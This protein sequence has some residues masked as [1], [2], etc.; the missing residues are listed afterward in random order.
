M[1]RF[2]KLTAAAAAAMLLAACGTG[3]TGGGGGGDGDNTDKPYRI[4]VSGGVSAP[5]VMADLSGTSINATKAAVEDVNDNG[6]IAGRKIELVVVDDAGDPTTA[7]T[8]LR[9]EIN[10]KGVDAYLNSGPSTIA[11]ATLPILTQNKILSFNIGPTAESSDPSAHP[12]NFDL[13]PG[14]AEYLAGF[15]VELEKTGYKKVGIIHGSTAYGQTFGKMAADML[16]KEGYEVVGKQEYD[17][18]ALDMTPQLQSLQSSKPEVLI[19]DGY[20]APVG[21]VLQSKEKLGWDVPMLANNSVA[22]TSIVSQPPPDGVLGTNQ[23]KGLKMQVAKSIKHDPNAE[24]VNH[25]VELMKKQG[26]IKTTLVQAYNWDAP[27]LI[28][29]AADKV[30][31]ADNAEELAKALEDPEVQEKAES[32]MISRYNFTAESHGPNVSG[33]EFIFVEPSE[34][35]DGQFQ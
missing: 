8:K 19:F 5:G 15:M 1:K 6:G 24:N 20:G 9:E 2:M 35:K 31:N 21:Y 26:P 3:Q 22:S 13:S 10:G 7:V 11:N 4:V 29:A 12:M 34:V 25:A 27:H 28:A 33:E 14:P 30:G 17:S 32:A 23:V 16:P 18:A